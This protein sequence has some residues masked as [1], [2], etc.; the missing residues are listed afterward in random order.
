[1]I[2]SEDI[3]GGADSMKRF[4]SEEQGSEGENDRAS[5]FH[6]GNNK[7]IG[8]NTIIDEKRFSYV[9]FEYD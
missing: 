8:Y 9:D 2:K 7:N 5:F 6:V 3:S 1:M 4:L